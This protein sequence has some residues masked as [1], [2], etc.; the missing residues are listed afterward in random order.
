MIDEIEDLASGECRW[1]GR[2][3]IHVYCRA[4]MVETL[5]ASGRMGWQPGPASYCVV[6]PEAGLEYGEFVDAPRAAKLVEK[7]LKAG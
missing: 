4:P 1:I 5:M 2:R 3:D 6:C 7:I